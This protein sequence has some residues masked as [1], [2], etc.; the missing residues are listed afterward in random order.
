MAIADA[1]ISWAMKNPIYGFGTLIGFVLGI[2]YGFDG[3]R[4]SS[5]GLD[6]KDSPRAKNFIWLLTG[7]LTTVLGDI[8]AVD[9]GASKIVL[10]LDYS[11][12]VVSGAG[13]VVL[14]WG[15]L[16]LVSCAVNRRKLGYDYGTIDALGDYFFFGYR[17]Y[18]A[19]KTER[20]EEQR[21]S[22]EYLKQLTYAITLAGSEIDNDKKAEFARSLLQSITAMVLR[23]R[24][25][26]SDAEIR[27]SLMLVEDCT[28]VLAARLRFGT[29][30]TPPTRCLELVAYD[31][32]GL[33]EGLVLPLPDQ[34]SA[35][36]LPGAPA[37]FINGATV[38]VDDT[39][40]LPFSTEI[41]PAVQSAM[42]DYFSSRNNQFRSFASVPVVAAGV[43]IAIIN[44]DCTETHVFGSSAEDKQRVVERLL[45]FCAALGVFLKRR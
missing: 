22:R 42:R 11:A 39:H 6:L 33:N 32:E 18:K 40:A 10:L 31:Q 5:E 8:K 25:E 35:E 3:W 34:Q 1:I 9:P 7:A 26:K 14:G 4:G 37:A 17:R 44:V 41:P 13:L 19:I 23:Y 30:A 12:A 43:P 20:I 45:P 38:I 24:G 16:V 15:V 36:V 21:R 28:P 27:T 2:F 29:A